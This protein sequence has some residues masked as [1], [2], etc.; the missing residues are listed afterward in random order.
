MR[1]LE[2][3]SY[4]VLCVI[5]CSSLL[6]S[7]CCACCYYVFFLLVWFYHL[8]VNKDVIWTTP[9]SHGVQHDIL[10]PASVFNV[11]YML[12]PFRLSSV[13]DTA[14]WNFRQ[15]FF[16]VWYL[17]HPLTSKKFFKILR[18]SC[19]GNPS[20]GGGGV[21]RKRVSQI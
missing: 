19:Q 3:L 6:V 21:K 1:K 10:C 9:L 8:L 2:S 4:G 13:C 5:L 15:F 20:V 18:R 14:V 7:C 17:G 12:S 16:A 11:R